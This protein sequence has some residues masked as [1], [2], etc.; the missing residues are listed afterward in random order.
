MSMITHDTYQR[1]LAAL[2]EGRRVVCASIVEGLIKDGITMRSLYAD[3]FHVSMYEIG[4]LWEQNRIS[5]A[6]EHLCTAITESLL[7]IVYPQVFSAT[8]V[9][10]S[11]V[12]SCV[13]NEY[14]QLGGKM[15][16]DIMEMHGWD[17]VFFGANTPLPGLLEAVQ[18]R[19]P[20]V[21]GLSFSVYYNLGALLDTVET[22]SNCIPGLPIWVGGQGFSVASHA[23]I[24]SLE[25]V[26]YIPSL[27]VLEKELEAMSSP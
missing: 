20:D 7:G 16:A 3:L 15:V 19:R 26:H 14:H 6:T 22:L 5:V 25:N 17:T 24:H 9:G 2:L 23:F 21:V 8:R 10:R 12:I 11:A 27:E 1:Y 18:A 13:A 4:T